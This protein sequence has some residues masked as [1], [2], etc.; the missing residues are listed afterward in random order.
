MLAHHEYA[1]VDDL[2]ELH[3]VTHCTVGVDH[4]VEG[5]QA[6][7]LQHE[8]AAHG[9][10]HPNKQ[11][12]QDNCDIVEERVVEG[13]VSGLDIHLLQHPPHRIK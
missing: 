6:T 11:H 5:L 7:G 9:C 1:V 8:L 3:V 10:N 13:G 2:H 12:E 4:L